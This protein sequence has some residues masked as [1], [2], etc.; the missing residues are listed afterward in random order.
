[1]NL[2]ANFC[3]SICQ[4]L[5]IG[6]I[7]RRTQC[8][9]LGRALVVQHIKHNWPRWEDECH[10][11]MQKDSNWLLLC[12]LYQPKRTQE[13][14]PISDAHH[15]AWLWLLEYPPTAQHIL[16]SNFCW[17]FIQLANLWPVSLVGVTKSEWLNKRKVKK[18]SRKMDKILLI[19]N[20]TSFC[21][22]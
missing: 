5:S 15:A 22:N 19:L 1:M 7:C 9:L 2:V 18:K 6:S 13:G 11:F 20:T 10:K 8:I 4:F 14:L 17:L 16:H 12:W 3:P 21:V